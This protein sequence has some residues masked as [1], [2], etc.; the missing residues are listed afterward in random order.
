[1][2]FVISIYCCTT[3]FILLYLAHVLLQVQE[4][5]TLSWNLVFAAHIYS[6][7]SVCQLWY[8]KNQKANYCSLPHSPFVTVKNARFI[9]F[10][11]T[12]QAKLTGSNVRPS[13]SQLKLFSRGRGRLWNTIVR[14]SIHPGHLPPT[15]IVLIFPK[16]CFVRFLW[17][18]FSESCLVMNLKKFVLFVINVKYRWAKHHKEIETAAPAHWPPYEV[19]YHYV[20][21]PGCHLHQQ[22]VIP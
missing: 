16:M 2:S 12:A 1:M 20:Q 7:C 21:Q 15:A 14:G 6:Q 9:N 18:G 19:S 17:C 4:L 11:I 5:R 22:L 8:V 3:S 10:I 13:D